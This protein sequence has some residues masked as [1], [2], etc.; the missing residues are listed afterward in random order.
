MRSCKRR[1][2]GWRAGFPALAM[3][4]YCSQ[5]ARSAS[6]GKTGGNRVRGAERNGVVGVAGISGGEFP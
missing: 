5:Q 2:V 6:D 1:L 4:A 3:G